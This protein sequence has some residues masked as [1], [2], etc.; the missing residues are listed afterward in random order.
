MDKNESPRLALMIVFILALIMMVGF[1]I[2]G[3]GMFG[4][5]QAFIFI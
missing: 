3:L 4:C 1:I 5:E 2:C